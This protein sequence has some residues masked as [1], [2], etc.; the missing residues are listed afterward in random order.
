[1]RS[2]TWFGKFWTRLRAGMVE[3]VPPNLEECESCREVDC[4]QERW[5]GCERRLTAETESLL[6]SGVRSPA[7]RTDE[8]PGVSTTQESD[9]VP[10]QGGE[11]E[12]HGRSRKISS[13]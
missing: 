3:D 6:G 13:Q 12:E 7:G 10:E 4:T 5:L 9:A 2:E 8:L 11:A 1:M